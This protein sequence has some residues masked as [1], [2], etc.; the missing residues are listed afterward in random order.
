VVGA[1]SLHPRLECNHPG[2]SEWQGD[3]YPTIGTT[4]SNPSYSST[5]KLTGALK[6][7]VLLEASF[8]Y[9]GNKIGIIPVS[10]VS[11]GF[12]KPTGWSTGTYFRR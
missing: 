3:N 9:D 11:A 12:T 5:I 10:T 4:F 7:N 6:P 8:N 1:R 2:H